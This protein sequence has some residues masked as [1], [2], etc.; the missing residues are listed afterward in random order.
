MLGQPL[1]ILEESA[2]RLMAS[3]PDRDSTY[4][5][6]LKE[7]SKL[8][9]AQYGSIFLNQ[10]H[11]RI[12]LK[13]VYSTVP[14]VQQLDPSSEDST[15]IVYKTG[16][17]I[18]IAEDDFN[19]TYPQTEKVF[20]VAVIPIK[21]GKKSIGVMT[22]QNFKKN[23]EDVD[24]QTLTLFGTLIG[25]SLANIELYQQKE[26]AVRLRDRF[27]SIISHELRT[28][29]TSIK[30]HAQLMQ[31]KMRQNKPISVKPVGIILQQ[32]KRLE[33]MITSVFT[34]NQFI[35]GTLFYSFDTFSFRDF[36]TKLHMALH[37]VYPQE[38]MLEINTE[39]ELV[40]FADEEKM[41][42]L[43]TN[44]LRN[45]SKYS[46]KDSQIKI[47]VERDDPCVLV[48][49][50]DTG[51]GVHSDKISSLFEKYVQGDNRKDGLGIGLY[52]VRKVAEDHGGIVS[53]SSKKDVGT[54]VTVAIPLK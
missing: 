19:T 18:F 46:A 16:K 48:S 10:H 43:V 2:L 53:F 41:Y 29:L 33:D 28:P 38:V 34:A 37:K 32:A 26:E 6:A 21:D 17:P 39:D 27:F 45:A 54:T 12:D 14:E 42:K 44:I 31:H 36:I 47:I 5:I 24:K 51:E 1:S 15:V 30:A 11:T 13:Q 3:I 35:S 25:M 23:L 7:G 50:I 4:R 52:I 22:L 8:V 49:V 40:V 9:D 20:S